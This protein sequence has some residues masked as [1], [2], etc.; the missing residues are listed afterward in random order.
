MIDV[1]FGYPDFTSQ[2]FDLRYQVLQVCGTFRYP[3]CMCLN[4]E[5]SMLSDLV[6]LLLDDGNAHLNWNEISV[7]HKSAVRFHFK[8]VART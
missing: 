4:E 8:F 6:E 3:D 2:D 1:T 7:N 5:I